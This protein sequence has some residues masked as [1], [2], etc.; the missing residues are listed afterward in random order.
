MILRPTF[1]TVKKD[2]L[3]NVNECSNDINSIKEL[4][5]QL[6]ASKSLFYLYLQYGDNTQFKFQICTE[7]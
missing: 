7:R 6:C 4:I 2:M 1:K 5:F 3:K